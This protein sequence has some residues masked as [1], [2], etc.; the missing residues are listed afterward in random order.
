MGEFFKAMRAS[1]VPVDRQE[2][3]HKVLAKAAAA[4]VIRLATDIRR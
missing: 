2:G 4:E 3:L 1:F